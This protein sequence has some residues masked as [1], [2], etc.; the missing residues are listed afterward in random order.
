MAH[1]GDGQVGVRPRIK[2]GDPRGGQAGKTRVFSRGE[3]KITIRTAGNE[4]KEGKIG[5]A[6]REQN[7]DIAVIGAGHAGIEAALAPARMGFSVALISFDG[8]GAGRMS[9]NPAIGGLAKGHLVREIDAL[10]GEMGRAIDAT[11]THFKM[12]NRSRGPAVW[13]PRAQ[14]D[15][16]LYSNYMCAA[17]E[18]EENIELIAA[19]VTGLDVKNGAVCGVIAAGRDRVGAAAVI[20]AAG[21][22][23]SSRMFVGDRVMEGGRLGECSA[24]R[25][26]KNMADLGFRTARLKTGTP[27]PH[28]G[29]EH[30]LVQDEGAETGPVPRALF[31]S[32]GE[33]QQG[34]DLLLDYR[35]NR[36]DTRPDSREH[37][38]LPPFR[39]RN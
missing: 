34:S 27:P 20:L 33:H 14:A 26:S 32:H 8:G 7:F 37:S 16:D 6:R 25:L 4:K 38:S 30:R 31:V 22:F 11:G 1:R 3:S 24:N 17:V 9:C 15:R 28:P 29:W 5:L 36:G 2:A 39:R 35:H 23:L 19:E 18:A 21:T 10:G 12:L 13:G